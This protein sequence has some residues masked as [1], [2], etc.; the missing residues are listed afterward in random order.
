[1]RESNAGETEC[2]R[3]YVVQHAVVHVARLPHLRFEPEVDMAPYVV[4]DRAT[5]H[6]RAAW[7]G[8]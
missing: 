6:P 5:V 2:L 7:Q 4:H 8:V 3:Q 1:M